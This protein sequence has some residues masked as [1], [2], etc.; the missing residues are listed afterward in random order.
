[1]HLSDGYRPAPVWQWEPLVAG[2]GRTGAE[3]APDNRVERLAAAGRRL[4]ETAD[5]G[6]VAA[7]GEMLGD[8]AEVTG[9][10]HQAPAGDRLGGETSVGEGH[11]Q[12]RTR[13]QH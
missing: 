4:V 6:P 8:P 9:L 5:I 13:P 12:R 3:A 10:V 7:L 2:A 11:D 1:M